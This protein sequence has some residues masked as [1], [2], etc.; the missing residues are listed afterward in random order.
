MEDTPITFTRAVDAS[1]L[2]RTREEWT[3]AIPEPKRNIGGDQQHGASR[4]IIDDLEDRA[5]GKPFVHD[6]AFRQ[7]EPEAEASTHS[8]RLGKG[9]LRIGFSRQEEVGQM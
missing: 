9:D 5:D 7:R 8:G 4:R 3:P 6:R 1:Q 2:T